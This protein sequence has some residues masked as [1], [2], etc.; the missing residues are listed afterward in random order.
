MVQ[1]QIKELCLQSGYNSFNYLGPWKEYDVYEPDM[2][3][4]REAIPSTGMPFFFLAK[5]EEVR[6][7]VPDEAFEI[8]DF[9][10]PDDE[11][12]EDVDEEVDN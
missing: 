11:D 7:T 12:E 9:F 1:N 3:T 2:D 5:G 4:D 6:R 8:I 10:Y